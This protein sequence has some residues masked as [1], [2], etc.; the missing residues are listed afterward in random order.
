[1]TPSGGRAPRAPGVI[2]RT[3]AGLLDAFGLLAGIAFAAVA[4]LVTANV[5]LRNL[6]ITN[7]P[8]LL[9]VSEY[10]LYGGTFLAA[11][12]VLRLGAHVRVDL[13]PGLLSRRAARM[14]T[15][16]AEI[17][18]LVFSLVLARHGFNVTHDAFS[19]GDMM[20]KE[21]VI[22]EWPLLAVIPLSASMLAIEFARRLFSG[23]ALDDRRDDAQAPSDGL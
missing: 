5:I 10:V 1:M 14:V 2:A 15:G 9:E 13:L 17:C 18:G 7:F 12:W 11:P 23:A 19:R 4:L 22:P 16:T 8:W 6:G 21:L 20:F 3:Y